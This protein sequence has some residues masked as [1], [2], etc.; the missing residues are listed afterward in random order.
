[1]AGVSRG[2]GALSPG[3]THS[4]APGFPWIL[5]LTWGSGLS[6][7]GPPRETTQALRPCL[8]R[9]VSTHLPPHRHWARWVRPPALL[10]GCLPEQRR[11]GPCGGAGGMRGGRGWA[12][13]P[14][15][16][17]RAGGQHPRR[18]PLQSRDPRL[19]CVYLWPSPAS[20]LREGAQRGPKGKLGPHPKPPSD[21]PMLSWVPRQTGAQI[22]R[23]TLAGSSHL[24]QAAVTLLQGI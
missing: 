12:W 24:G 3:H 14:T 18:A 22:P 2:T 11:G 19:E 7:P 20:C 13:G 15:G 16:A 1:M 4:S 23:P 8:T 9:A 10:P 5:R 17:G 6:L 21:A